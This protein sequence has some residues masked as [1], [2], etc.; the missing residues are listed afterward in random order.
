M[1]VQKVD[2][3]M[4]QNRDRFKVHDAMVIREKLLA[5]D[6]SKQQAIFM[7]ELKDPT[8]MLIIS[9]FLGYLGIDRFMLGDIPMGILKLLTCGL[10][11]ILAIIDWIQIM[12][13]TKEKNFQELCLVLQS[14]YTNIVSTITS[15]EVLVFLCYED[16]YILL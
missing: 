4:M 7:V 13:R 15:A 16:T 14:L 2:L 10:C 9:I 1:D 3:F 12:D 6:D 5:L 11:G 8:M